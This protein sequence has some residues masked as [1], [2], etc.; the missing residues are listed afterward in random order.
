VG[1][2]SGSYGDEYEGGCLRGCCGVITLM[3]EAVSC[4]ETSVSIYHTAPYPRRQS[5]SV[6][7]GFLAKRGI[8]YVRIQLKTILIP[9]TFQDTKFQDINQ[10]PHGSW[11]FVSS[12]GT[13]EKLAS[14][15]VYLIPADM[16]SG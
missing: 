15:S 2:I 9:S 12:L 13:E 5:S 14:S 7:M 10:V 16:T 6:E 4:S 3:I 8:E 11:T 1:E